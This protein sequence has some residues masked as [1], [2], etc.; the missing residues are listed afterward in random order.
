LELPECAQD[1]CEKEVVP[2]RGRCCST[3][4]KKHDRM[5]KKGEVDS[6]VGVA[7]VE[8]RRRRKA[9]VRQAGAGARAGAAGRYGG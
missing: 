8:R 9:G 4:A 6:G 2:G 3:H 7:D 5:Q 1:G